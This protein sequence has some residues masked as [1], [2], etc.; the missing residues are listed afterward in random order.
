[1][2]VPVMGYP[3]FIKPFVLDT[4][5]SLQGLGAILSQKDENGKIKVIAYGS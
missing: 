3:D 4:D 1:M 2:S 5:A